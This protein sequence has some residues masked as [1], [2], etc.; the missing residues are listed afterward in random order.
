MED[1]CTLANIHA[2]DLST[3]AVSFAFLARA[4]SDAHES[5]S[6]LDRAAFHRAAEFALMLYTEEKARFTAVDCSA[7]LLD[8]L[9]LKAFLSDEEP[10]DPAAAAEGIARRFHAEMMRLLYFRPAPKAESPLETP[11][12]L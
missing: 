2:D 7:P 4:L 9:Y 5:G 12:P 10:S 3:H 8:S 11:R 1:L 6:R